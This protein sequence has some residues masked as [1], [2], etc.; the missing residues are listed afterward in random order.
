[1]IK[2]LISIKYPSELERAVRGGADIVDVKEPSRGSLGLPDYSIVKEVLGKIKRLGIAGVEV[3]SAGGDVE[4]VNPYIEYVAYT[5]A[6]LGV[7]Y[8]K[9]GLAARSIEDAREVSLRV[10]EVLESFN[11]TRLVLVGYADFSRAGV[12][13]PLK[14]TEVASDVEADVVM[15]DTYVKDGRTTFDFLSTNYLENFVKEAHGNSLLAALA[16]SLKKQHI[17]DAIKLGFD[18]VGF[19]GAVCTGGRDGVISEKLVS[20]LKE[21]IKSHCSCAAGDG[22]S[23]TA[24]RCARL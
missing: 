1:M 2:L 13:E 18:I 19:R 9:I 14:V 16:G 3:S 7:N 21:T 17:V 4:K 20:E 12:I 24:L 22:V 6:S 5:A 8:F 10:S 23:T 15:I 11:S